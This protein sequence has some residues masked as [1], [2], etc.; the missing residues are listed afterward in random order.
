MH[1]DRNVNDERKKKIGEALHGTFNGDHSK[2]E[3][4]EL[5]NVSIAGLMVPI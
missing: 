2:A 3:I 5:A 1:N 4:Q